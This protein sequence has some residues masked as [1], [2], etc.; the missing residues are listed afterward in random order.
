MSL[1]VHLDQEIEQRLQDQ[2]R[3]SGESLDAIVNRSLKFTLTPVQSGQPQWDFIPFS[4]QCP[5]ISGTLTPEYRQMIEEYEEKLRSN[6]A[7]I[8]SD[9]HQ[10]PRPRFVV[11][12]FDLGETPEKWKGLTPSQILHEMDIDEYEEKRDRA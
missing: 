9:K 8:A 11:K 4:Q 10:F 3:A 5:D 6:L 1:T 2:A 12:P 7:D